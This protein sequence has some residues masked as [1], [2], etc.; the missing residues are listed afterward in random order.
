MCR[1]VEL[2]VQAYNTVEEQNAHRQQYSDR[3]KFIADL[4][5]RHFERVSRMK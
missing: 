2:E 4:K 3:A 5:N 1:N